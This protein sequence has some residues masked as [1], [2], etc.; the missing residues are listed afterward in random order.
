M[1]YS[2]SIFDLGVSCH[3]I[4]RFYDQG[5]AE[6]VSHGRKQGL[7]EGRDLG[8]QKG[9]EMWEEIGFYEGF[10]RMWNAIYIK[11]GKQDEY[12]Y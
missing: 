11:Q 1:P 9:F 4:C 2:L 5:W 7:E 6:G 10:A 12:V 8:I 3:I